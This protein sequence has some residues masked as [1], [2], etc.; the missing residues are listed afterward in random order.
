MA[1]KIV[2]GVTGASGAVYARRLLQALIRAGSHIHLIVSE[3]GR[4]VAAAEL[5]DS[6]LLVP[7][8]VGKARLRTHRHDDLFSP[9]ASGSNPTDAMLICPCTCHTLSAVAT[10][11]ADNLITRAAHVH[12]KERRP[13]IIC[14]REMPISHVDLENMLR[15]SQA[16]GVIC[17]LCPPFYGRPKT[18]DDIVNEV[19]G[20]LLD[21]LNIPNDL[22]VRW[23]R[24]EPDD[25]ADGGAGI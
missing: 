13:L 6:D 8:V 22:A 12:L 3:L 17:P 20:R 15:I 24:P 19:V 2:V 23:T 14:L 1:R 10:G 11:L 7:P 5:G 18:V 9:L 21:L 16:G 4:T 25:I